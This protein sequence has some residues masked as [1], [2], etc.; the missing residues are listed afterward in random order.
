LPIHR[1]AVLLFLLCVS[2]AV[3]LHAESYDAWLSMFPERE[4]RL[5][6]EPWEAGSVGAYHAVQVEEGNRPTLGHVAELDWEIASRPVGGLIGHIH[7]ENIPANAKY[8]LQLRLYYSQLLKDDLLPPATTDVHSLYWNQPMGLLDTRSP[9]RVERQYEMTNLADEETAT[10]GIPLVLPQMPWSFFSAGGD[11]GL[12]S[13]RADLADAE[14]QILGRELL[15][16]C[17]YASGRMGGQ[18]A[19]VREEP[20]A[21]RLLRELAGMRNLHSIERFPDIIKPYSEIS[22]LWMSGSAWDDGEMDPA[23]VRRLML[24]GLWIYGRDETITAVREAVGVEEDGPILLGGLDVPDTVTFQARRINQHRYNRTAS[25]WDQSL[26]VW[27]K[28]PKFPLENREGLFRPLKKFFAAYTL[29]ILIGFA[30][31]S[32]IGLPL[33]FVFLKGNR[34]M[35]LWWGAPIL[36]VAFGVGGWLLGLAVLDHDTRADATEYRLAYAGWPE[37]Y[38]HSVARQLNFNRQRATWM[39][40]L[41]LFTWSFNSHYQRAKKVDSRTVFHADNCTFYI[42]QGLK[43]GSVY[44]HE[45]AWFDEHPLPVR[46]D[47]S[48]PGKLEALAPLRGVHVWADSKWHVIGEMK[49]GMSVSVEPAPTTNTVL[50][51]PSRLQELFQDKRNDRFP[52]EV[53]AMIDANEMPHPDAFKDKAWIVLAV[54]DK[55]GDMHFTD[56]GEQSGRVVWVVQLPIVQSTGEGEAQNAD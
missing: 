1:K 48:D 31:V 34:R 22:A 9:V 38:C 19:W 46:V 6:L 15:I 2:A 52:A 16:E 17:Y 37:V 42:I 54:A 8:P 30:L 20:E 26:S 27:Q 5:S 51:L 12:L 21:D 3:Q 39:G 47:T 11:K 45:F 29:F 32:G 40:P 4:A 14:G 25:F 28:D 18:A 13:C 56:E 53:Q 23:F 33:A 36:A 49:A 35:R 10:A 41:N 55:D 7:I 44:K 50:G 24:M 43:R